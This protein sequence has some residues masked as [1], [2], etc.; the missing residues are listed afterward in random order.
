MTAYLLLF[1]GLLLVFLEFYLPGAVMG[2][3]GAILIVLS[4]AWYATSDASGLEILI[5]IAVAIGGVIG[6]INLALWSI[7]RTG[8]AKSIFLESDQEGYKASRYEEELIGKKG[9]C[10]TSLRPGGYVKIDGKKYAAISVSGL[11][12]KQDE[13]EVMEIEG[14]TLKV[15]KI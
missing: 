10:H 4:I 11:L 7:R 5:F 3:A 12:D 1:V 8:K 14:E 15:R 13:I 9:H 2:T 6:V